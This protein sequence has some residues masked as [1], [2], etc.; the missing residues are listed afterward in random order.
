[1]DKETGGKKKKKGEKKKKKKKKCRK[2]WKAEGGEKEK[3]RRKARRSCLVDNGTVSWGY[4]NPRCEGMCCFLEA[5][6]G[7]V[8]ARIVNSPDK[9]K[10]PWRG[11]DA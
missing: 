2:E 9:R 3:R 8:A 10:P 6:G 1:M 4:G 5:V 7:R 11:Q